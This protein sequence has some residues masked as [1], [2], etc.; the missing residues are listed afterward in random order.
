CRARQRSAWRPTSAAIRARYRFCSDPA[1]LASAPPGDTDQEAEADRKTDRGQRT[2][3]DGVLQRLL[4]RGCG[5]LRGTHHGAAAF[6]EI[7]DGAFRRSAGLVVT[8]ARALFGDLAKG[9]ERIGH[10]AG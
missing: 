2:L 1:W 10:L 7:A 8:M 4:D 9:V 6:G 3:G 5:V